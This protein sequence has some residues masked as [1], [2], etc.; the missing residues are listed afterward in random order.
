MSMIE[1]AF[2]VLKHKANQMHSKSLPSHM[3]ACMGQSQSLPHCTAKFL[4][5]YITNANL[6]HNRRQR[7]CPL[8]KIITVVWKY[9][10][11]SAREVTKKK[12][13]PKSAVRLH[14]KATQ[15]THLKA[16][17]TLIWSLAD[18]WTLLRVLV[19]FIM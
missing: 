4:D 16:W 19:T 8:K 5:K 3:H 6:W 14:P 18:A 17:K 12:S 13:Y 11:F 10:R 1:Y 9:F 2:A 15:V 7:A